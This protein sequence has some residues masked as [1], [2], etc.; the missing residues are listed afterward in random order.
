M[1]IV[2]FVGSQVPSHLFTYSLESSVGQ[3]VGQSI[4]RYVRWSDSWS[5]SR[6]VRWVVGPFIG[7]LVRRL[8][9]RSVDQSVGLLDR[10]TESC[11]S[12]DSSQQ[13][14]ILPLS[15]DRFKTSRW[16]DST[17]IGNTSFRLKCC[18]CSSDG[19][20]CC[21]CFCCCLSPQGPRLPPPPALTALFP[22]YPEIHPCFI[23]VQNF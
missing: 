3:R 5:D 1:E 21:C 14:T 18:S 2:I 12:S 17:D 13:R 11:K 15:E 16:E 9:Y 4:G 7:P 22:R 8:V 20:C 19:C 23:R 10:E 6:S